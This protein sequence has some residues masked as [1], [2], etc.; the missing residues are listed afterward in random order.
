M[1]RTDRLLAIVLELQRHRRSYC[2]AEDLATRFEVSKRTIYR[3]I[4]ALCE[5]GVPIT[6]A[7][8]QG[9][10]LVE[11]YFLPP[12]SFTAAEALILALGSDFMA[13]NFDHDYRVAA[14][15]AYRKIDAVLPPLLRT[16]VDHLKSGLH[17][18]ATHRLDDDR[19]KALRDLRQAVAEHKRIR[20]QYVKRDRASNASVQ[21]LREVDPYH[22]T[23]LADDWYV[24]GYCHLRQ[25][26][27]VFRLTRIDQLAILEHTFEY[28]EAA[29]NGRPEHSAGQPMFVQVLFDQN[30]ARWAGES[31]R[32]TLIDQEETPAGVRMMLLTQSENDI[33]RWLLSWGGDVR[34]LE[35]AWLQTALLVHAERMLKNYRPALMDD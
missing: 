5:A 27:R 4:Q 18:F 20:I 19:L 33:V 28:S 24:T 8:R 34:V 9:Y 29:A 26:M 21:T 31:H 35:P 14:H 10:A 3:D 16:Q 6:V 13:H 7:D 11:G 22:L 30:A 23:R 2:R 25:A 15:S 32:Y 17:F 12:L 1:N